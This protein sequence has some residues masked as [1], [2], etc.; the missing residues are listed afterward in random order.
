MKLVARHRL[1]CEHHCKVLQSAHR[2]AFDSSEMCPEISQAD[3]RSQSDICQRHP[4][5]HH[6]LL[7]RR[8]GWRCERPKIHFWECVPTRRSSNHL[9]KQETEFC[10]S[11]YGRS[12]IYDSQCRN[13]GGHMAT[14]ASGGARNGRNRP[15]SD[16]RRQSGCDIYG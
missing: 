16:L 2:T 12:R 8:L 14:T 10:C 7:G 15:D 9:V 11:V 13:A 5:S 1:S 6:R 4:R 3:P